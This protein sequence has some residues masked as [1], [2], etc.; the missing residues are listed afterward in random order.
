MHDLELE[1][2][3]TVAKLAAARRLRER[4]FDELR[5]MRA[6]GIDSTELE[7][8]LEDSK[9]AIDKLREYRNVLAAE[10]LRTRPI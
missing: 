1:L 3:E 5:S 2:V 10:L 4:Y 6:V 9:E 8:A 7:R